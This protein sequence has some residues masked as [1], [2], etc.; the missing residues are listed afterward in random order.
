MC[1]KLA[2]YEEPPSSNQCTAMKAM[3]IGDAQRYIRSVMFFAV[4]C[5][6]T[7]SLDRVIQVVF[8]V[9]LF[10]S[11][12]AVISVIFCW[13]AHLRHGELFEKRP[14]IRDKYNG[15]YKRKY[16]HCMWRM[17][18]RFLNNPMVIP[19]SRVQPF[20]WVRKSCSQRDG[21]SPSDLAVTQNGQLG[22][23]EC[24]PHMNRIHCGYTLVW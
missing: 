2:H 11:P 12:V 10:Q 7:M 20:F 18:E 24:V 15:L 14:M 17:V 16:W 3:S 8:F 22:Q 5:C 6:D 4:P 23:H 21:S 13:A 9:C 19:S 1:I